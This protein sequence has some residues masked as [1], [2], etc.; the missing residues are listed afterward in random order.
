MRDETEMSEGVFKRKRRVPN[1]LLVRDA[2]E[3]AKIVRN[4]SVSLSLFKFEG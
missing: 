2:S 4:R 1:V 3:A